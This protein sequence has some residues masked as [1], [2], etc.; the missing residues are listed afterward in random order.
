MGSDS[1]FALACYS[2]SY[3]C[4]LEN[5]PVPMYNKVT[6][7]LIDR[8]HP[9]LLSPTKDDVGVLPPQHQLPSFASHL[10]CVLHFQ[11]QHITLAS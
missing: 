1:A 8:S 3:L 10:F 7:T 6:F 11:P 5:V 9:P 4:R 2:T